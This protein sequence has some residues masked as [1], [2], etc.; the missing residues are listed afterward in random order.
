MTTEQFNESVTD[1]IKNLVALN[2]AKQGKT[3]PQR[4]LESIIPKTD[5]PTIE[6]QQEYWRVRDKDLD[7]IESATQWFDQQGE[8]HPFN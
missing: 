5:W 4:L 3:Q 2:K 1:S 7:K 8:K 6:A